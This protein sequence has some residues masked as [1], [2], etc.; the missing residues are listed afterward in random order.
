MIEKN[1]LKYPLEYDEPTRIME[2][3]NE[4]IQE[5]PVLKARIIWFNNIL[6]ERLQK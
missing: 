1:L 6:K 3:I 2:I 5:D 4:E